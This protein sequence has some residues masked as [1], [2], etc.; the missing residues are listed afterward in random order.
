MIKV[1]AFYLVGVLV[2]EKDNVLDEYEE[3]IERL[4]GPNISEEKYI[5]AVK[6]INNDNID[7]KKYTK[8]IINKLYYIKDIDLIKS[9]KEKY[10]NIKIIVA[11]NHVTYVKEYINSNFKFLD[12]II[13]SMDINLIKPSSDFY[14]YIL[15]K[16]NI[17]NNELLFIDD[18]ITNIE[19]AHRLGIN[20]IKVDMHTNI[21]DEICKIISVKE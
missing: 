12:D 14:M 10:P 9:I 17:K 3:K 7:I 1:I 4:F 6:N 2:S 18:N 20:T 5:D 15:N 19:G 16:Y 11:T 8:S 13:I 21:L